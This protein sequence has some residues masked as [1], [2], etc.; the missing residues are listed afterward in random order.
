MLGVLAQRLCKRICNQCKGEHEHT[1]LRAGDRIRQVAGF[2]TSDPWTWDAGQFQEWDSV[3][4][5]EAMRQ[6]AHLEDDNLSTVLMA[7]WVD[8]HPVSQQSRLTGHNELPIATE[9]WVLYA[10]GIALAVL[11]STWYYTGQ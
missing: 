10:V 11:F 8:L 1:V 7:K 3:Q 2:T 9:L 6:N 5:G 4:G